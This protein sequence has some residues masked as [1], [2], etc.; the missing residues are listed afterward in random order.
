M[1]LSDIST[2]EEL[3]ESIN[4]T[5]TTPKRPG[6]QG[7]ELGVLLNKIIS[8]LPPS[9]NLDGKVD[10]T[11]IVNNLNAT[12]P[13]GV[14]DAMQGKNLNDAISGKVDASAIA[15]VLTTTTA[16]KVLDA[17]Q[18]KALNDA[19][20]VNTTAIS[21]ESNRAYQQEN[22]RIWAQTIT[23]IRARNTADVALGFY[24]R[25]FGKEGLFL[26]D[27]TDTT[28]AD[29][30]V[31][32]LVDAHGYRYKRSSAVQVINV[33]NLGAKGDGTT[34]D[35]A[36]LQAAF[37]IAGLNS[38]AGNTRI[39]YI[40]SGTYLT[41]TIT[42][43][44]SI[45][46]VIGDSEFASVLL[47]KPSIT[48]AVLSV[49]TSTT[50]NF[51]SF[52]IDGNKASLT[53]INGTH[54]GIQMQDRTNDGTY[55]KTGNL[56]H[57]YI[58]NTDGDGFHGGAYRQ[59]FLADYI[60]TINTNGHGIYQHPNAA[61]WYL[62]KVSI[63]GAGGYGM[64]LSTMCNVD[65][66]Y[67]TQCLN[68]VYFGQYTRHSTLRG[69]QIDRHQQSAIVFEGT[70]TLVDGVSLEYSTLT[71]DG[72]WLQNCSQAGDGTYP[73]IKVISGSFLRLINVNFEG[74]PTDINDSG[75]QASYLV[76]IT[77]SSVNTRVYFDDTNVVSPL[78]YRTDRFSDYSR[79]IF[80]GGAVS[81]IANR[82]LVADANYTTFK[83]DR[84]IAVT[85]L[86]AARTIT[87]GGFLQ[88][89]LKTF[90]DESGQAGTYNITIAAPSG[91][92][93]DGTS[94]K[95]ISTNYGSVKIYFNGTNY[96]TI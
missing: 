41:G 83:T 65:D 52:G 77:G 45:A 86:T 66:G 61:D 62:N 29:D 60:Y 71:I 82:T 63:T 93:I 58:R 19:I 30:G 50:I 5:C 22:Q 17:R 73:L 47:A 56:S 78:A 2:I 36:A 79:V 3:I 72:C 9:L 39:V 95:V 91:K 15:N 96:F 81:K 12:N 92:T 87:L 23:Q 85:S 69:L 4:E 54:H 40:P 18:G 49:G 11:A 13:G 48:G 1:A 68:G 8:L 80:T 25:D 46:T 94:T 57:V 24:V 88:N 38:W 35:T 33:R 27:T 16:G 84:V 7:Y 21:T 89:D 53:T 76:Q 44:G 10:V 37:D 51:R 43:T 67:I 59:E 20:G 32:T 14:L 70:D 64:Y 75:K 28:T 74:S 55:V 6:I 26:V 31:R 34:D 42:V 90:K